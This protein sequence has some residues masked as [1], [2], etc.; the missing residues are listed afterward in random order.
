MMIAVM[1]ALRSEDPRTKV[2]CVGLTREG[3][4][5]GTGY[6]GLKP[7]K[8]LTEKEWNCKETKHKNIIH[9][10]ENLLTVIGERRAI[11]DLHTIVITL[12]PCPACAVDLALVGVHRI[13]YMHHTNNALF[14]KA[15]NCFI[16]S[17]IAIKQLPQKTIE[18]LW[19][20]KSI[21]NRLTDYKP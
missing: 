10:E 9:A 19:P 7:G 16:T 21:L 2:G 1:A 11:K 12:F 15:A 20:E 8:M 3:R 4:I 18:N 6:N 13:I 5:L 17:N 14:F